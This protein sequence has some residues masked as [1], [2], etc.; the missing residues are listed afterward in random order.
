MFVYLPVVAFSKYIPF[1][2]GIVVIV[3]VLSHSVAIRVYCSIILPVIS[4]IAIFNSVPGS[5]G[6]AFYMV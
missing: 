5:L 1:A 6:A 3:V 4:H 2:L